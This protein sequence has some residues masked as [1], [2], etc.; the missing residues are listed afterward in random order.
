[1]S[2]EEAIRKLS[3]LPAEIL[4]LHDRGRLEPDRF[5]DI[6]VLDPASIA[7]KATFEDPFHYSVGVKHLFVNG[8][9]VV[10]DEAPYRIFQGFRHG[11]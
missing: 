7:G 8:V 1:M 6:V 5:A 2:W 3:A 4:G 10:R 11:V 9:A